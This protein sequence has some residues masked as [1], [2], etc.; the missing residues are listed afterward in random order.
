MTADVSVWSSVI[1]F[2]GVLRVLFPRLLRS[3]V[4]PNQTGNNSRLARTGFH[5]RSAYLMKMPF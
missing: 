5:G 2:I 3:L 1:R 4:D